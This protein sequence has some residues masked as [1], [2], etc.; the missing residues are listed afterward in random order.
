MTVLLGWS[1]AL[2]EYFD[3]NF[4]TSMF[5]ILKYTW[6]VFGNLR[7]SLDPLGHQFLH[8]RIFLGETIKNGPST[9]IDWTRFCGQL[10]ENVCICMHLVTFSLAMP[11]TDYHAYVYVDQICGRMLV[12]GFICFSFCYCTHSLL[13]MVSFSTC[14]SHLIL[15]LTQSTIDKIIV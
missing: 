14:S 10:I 8:L 6:L 13:I 7:N 9:Q 4:C 3:L 1:T 2:L 5:W 11:T 12:R 15:R